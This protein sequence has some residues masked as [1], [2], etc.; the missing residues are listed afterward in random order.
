MR[1]SIQMPLPRSCCLLLVLI[2]I[3]S[4]GQSARSDE[5]KTLYGIHDYTPDPTAYL[6]HVTNAAGCGWITATVA[7]GHD[8]SVTSGTNFS[9][10]ADR[11]HTVICRINNGYFPDGT[12]PLSA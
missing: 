9:T 6:N 10:L 3:C 1:L 8:A 4:P 5:C 2:A 12:I 7:I 11:G